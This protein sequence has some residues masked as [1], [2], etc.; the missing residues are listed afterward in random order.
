VKALLEKIESIMEENNPELEV[1][2][3]IATRFDGRKVINRQ[4]VQSLRENFGMLLLNTMIRENIV[5]AESPSAGKD[6]FTYRPRSHG[7][8]DYLNLALEIMGQI[9][10]AESPITVERGGVITL[11]EPAQIAS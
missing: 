2:G 4:V 10:A 1:G 11:H 5:L 8:E 9:T 6:I 7:A 3:I